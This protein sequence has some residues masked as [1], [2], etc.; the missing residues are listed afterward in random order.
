MDV[1]F[2]HVLFY[3]VEFLDADDDPIWKEFGLGDTG[4]FPQ[5]AI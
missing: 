2:F 1:I 3:T 4:P 5:L